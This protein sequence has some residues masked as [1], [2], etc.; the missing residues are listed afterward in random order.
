MSEKLTFIFV[1]GLAGLEAQGRQ[2][3]VTVEDPGLPVPDG[4]LYV[5]TVRP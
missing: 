5:A 3:Q 2:P 1:H 4:V